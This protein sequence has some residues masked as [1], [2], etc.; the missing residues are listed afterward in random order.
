MCKIWT[1]SEWDTREDGQKPWAIDLDGEG[2]WVNRD[3]PSV[4]QIDHFTEEYDNSGEGI[5][6]I[7]RVEQEQGWTIDEWSYRTKY[8]ITFRTDDIPPWPLSTMVTGQSL[9][10]SKGVQIVPGHIAAGPLPEDPAIRQQFLDFKDTA[11]KLNSQNCMMKGLTLGRSVSFITAVMCEMLRAY[12]VRSL[13]PVYEVWNRNWIMHFACASSFLLTVS[14]TFIP[15][16][17]ELFKLDTPMWF[18]YLIA[19][20]FALGSMTID[21]ISKWMFRRVLVQ[22]E[23]GDQG[24]KERQEIKD[25]VDMVVEKLHSIELGIERNSGETV[26]AINKIKAEIGDV[27]GKAARPVGVL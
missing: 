26:S 9:H 11:M 15:G 19:F 7:S 14:L 2:N 12:T 1:G 10:V 18:Y 21:E 16:V 4:T 17:K 6:T 5:T 3:R 23:S 22:R 25:R 24:V 27:V 8:E 20:L 13:Q